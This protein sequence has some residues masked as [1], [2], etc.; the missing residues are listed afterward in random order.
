MIADGRTRVAA[1]ATRKEF[2]LGDIGPRILSTNSSSPN[3]LN[4]AT[5]AAANASR[6]RT[7]LAFLAFRITQS[8]H[9]VAIPCDEVRLHSTYS[10]EFAEE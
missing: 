7:G 4:S 2:I 3:C 8:P 9:K 5:A 10:T 6:D 1:R